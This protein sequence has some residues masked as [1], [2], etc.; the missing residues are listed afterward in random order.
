MKHSRLIISLLITLFLPMLFTHIR[1]AAPEQ[2]DLKVVETMARSRAR[3]LAGEGWIPMTETPIEE[4]LRQHLV[5]TEC[6]GM[7]EQPGFSTKTKNRNNGRMLALSNAMSRY[8]DSQVSRIKGHI[9][10]QLSADD[11]QSSDLEHFYGAFERHLE[12]EIRSVLTESLALI[13]ENDGGLCE[14]QILY[15]L[16]PDKESVALANAINNAAKETQL[17]DT[18]TALISEA[19]D[20][21]R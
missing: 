21:K 13:R 6:E 10:R 1:A 4:S 20:K 2:K 14:I 3:E 15:L 12:G 18:Y 5:A 9:S 8:T 16:N 7:A 17:S 11:A 19:L